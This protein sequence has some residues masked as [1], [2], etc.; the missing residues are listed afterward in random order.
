MKQRYI[1]YFRTCFSEGDK[2]SMKK[3][4]III[5][6]GPAGLTAAYELLLRTDIQPIVL[7]K[8]TDIGGLCKTVK[9]RGNRMDI[10][11]HRFFS[12]SDR[13][14]QWWLNILPLEYKADRDITIQYQQKSRPLD[15]S[16]FPVSRDANDENVMLVRNRISRIFYLRKFFSYPLSFSTDTIRKLGVSKLVKIGMSY[17]KSRLF[18]RKEEKTLEDFFINRFGKELYNTFFK[19]YTEKVWGVPCNTIPAEW[20]AQRVKGLSIGKAVLHALQN[21]VP[22]KKDESI[23]QKN[24]QTSLIERFLYPKYGP[25]QLWEEVAKIVQEKGGEIHFSMDVTK[26]N[27]DNKAVTSIEAVNSITG[28]LELFEGD[29]F[30]SSMPVNELI[31][32]F[33]PAAPA[34]VVSVAKG[35]QYRDF[36]TVGLLLKKLKVKN[37]DPGDQGLIKD[38]WIYMQEQSV[39]IGRLQIFNNWSPYLVKDAETVW[40]GL[41]YFCRV[42]DELWSMPDSVFIQFAIAELAGLGFI[43]KEDVLDSTIVRMEKT[44][45]AYFG[46]YERFDVIRK[47]TDSF[48][49]LFLVGRNGMHKYNNSDHSMLTAMTA[50]DNIVAEIESKENIWAINTEQEYH[51][52][53]EQVE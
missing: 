1:L 16:N 44:Y 31:N 51:E 50:V 48:A 42:G 4:A 32:G 36:I 24:K 39:K 2:L 30:F 22:G 41:E 34:A 38:S 26:I 17:L 33:T 47:Y 3:K 12:K 20:G 46:A 7:E 19:D 18:P 13:V 15:I 5:G 40:L 11:G 49:N 52:T 21:I 53:Q 37:D 43:D 25:G 9:Y 6:A 28:N 10:G 29:F 8:S 23:T 27:H 45:P 35:L 14:M